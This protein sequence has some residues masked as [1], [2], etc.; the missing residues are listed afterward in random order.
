MQLG[1]SFNVSRCS[2]CMACIVACLD[3]NDL[4]DRQSAYRHVISVEKGTYPDVDLR[5]VSL[6][7]LHCSDAPCMMACPTGAITRNE[8]NGIVDVNPDICVGCHSCALACPFG[9]SRYN[10][11]YKMSKCHFCIDRVRHG[12]A[13]ACVRICPTRALDFGPMERLT[14]QKAEG[15]SWSLLGTVSLRAVL[16]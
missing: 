15:S 13:P 4:K 2:G 8:K 9:A 12:L 16:K 14:R 6:S 5:F 10:D 7:C 3:E 1:F 11:G